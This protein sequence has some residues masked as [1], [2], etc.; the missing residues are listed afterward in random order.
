[1]A[2]TEHFAALPGIDDIRESVE[3]NIISGPWEYARYFIR[4]YLLNGAAR[5]AGNSPTTVLRPGLLMTA[6]TTT[7]KWQQWVPGDVGGVGLEDIKAVLLYAVDT[8]RDAANQDRWF[9]YM[10]I[11]GCVKSAGLIVP[12]NASPGINGDGN[13]ATIRSQMHDK[14]FILDDFWQ[15][16]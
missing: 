9:G 1:M 14:R 2:F 15:E 8:Q 10:L 11:G 12:G 4:G 7:K 5:D 13:E 6:N 3:S 16:P